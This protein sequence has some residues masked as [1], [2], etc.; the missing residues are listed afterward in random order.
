MALV[1]AA[2][3]FFPIA[4]ATCFEGLCCSPTGGTPYDAV[5]GERLQMRWRHTA[6]LQ[7][8]VEVVFVPLLLPTS[9]P[10]AA[11]E[12]AEEE[13]AR[14]AALRHPADMPHPPELTLNDESLDADAPNRLENLD[15]WNTICPAETQDTLQ[16]AYVEGL[17]APNLSPVD[18]PGLATVQENGN[19][20]RAVHGDFGGGG[21]VPVEEH[22]MRQTAEGARGP[23]KPVLDLI[24]EVAGRAQHTPEVNETLDTGHVVGT[25]PEGHIGRCFITRRVLT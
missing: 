24:V 7:Q 9:T 1:S 14:K 8:R 13:F 25:Y 11:G 23:A 6:L 5:G 16:A 20:D 12:F 4:T 22:A 17:E 10:S 18:S 19:A 21:E 2:T 3:S 15:V